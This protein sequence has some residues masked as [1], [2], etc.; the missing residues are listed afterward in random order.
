MI[1]Y[2]VRLDNEIDCLIYTWSI[3]F[4]EKQ[5]RTNSP[6]FFLVATMADQSVPV[7][8]SLKLYQALRNAGVPRLFVDM[9]EFVR[10][11]FSTHFDIDYML[12]PANPGCVK[13]SA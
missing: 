13:V 11:K 9:S 8:N 10:V 12:T 5:V 7:E 4:T 3:D 6:P 2:E 1:E